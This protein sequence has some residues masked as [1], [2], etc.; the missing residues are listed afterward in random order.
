MHQRREV[1]TSRMHPKLML[2]PMHQM[3]EVA[4][5]VASGLS[6]TEMLSPAMGQAKKVVVWKVPE[7]R[8]AECK[9]SEILDSGAGPLHEAIASCLQKHGFQFPQGHLTSIQAEHLL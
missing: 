7:L 2:S 8:L 1:A 3:M 4:P 5:T 6:P 9:V